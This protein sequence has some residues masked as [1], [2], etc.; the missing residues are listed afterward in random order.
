MKTKY[1]IPITM[2]IDFTGSELMQA[3][4]QPSSPTD[5]PMAPARTKVSKVYV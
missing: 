3:Q 1:N 5:Y 2:V 4:T